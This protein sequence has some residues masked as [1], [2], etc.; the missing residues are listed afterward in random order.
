MLWKIT[1]HDL[2]CGLVLLSRD[3]RNAKTPRAA[4]SGELSPVVRNESRESSVVLEC[5]ILLLYSEFFVALEKT[6]SFH[7][8]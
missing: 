6:I 5:L 1:I 2:T 7:H 8:S 4:F 3:D